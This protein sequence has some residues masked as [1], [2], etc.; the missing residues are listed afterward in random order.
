MEAI[1]HFLEIRATPEAVYRAVTEQDGLASWWTVETIA[2]PVVSSVAE[3][4][5][6]S[7]YHNRMRVVNLQ[8]V[9]RVEWECLDGDPEWIGTK[10]VFDI[11]PDG[12]SAFLLFVHGNWR[13]ATDFFASCNYHWGHYMRSL[14]SYCETGVGQ[15]YRSEE[16]E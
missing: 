15:P 5:F 4:R 2:E 3:F 1:R 10:F 12:D 8:P 9:Q 16:R 14:K 13:E 6:G 11:R 7:R